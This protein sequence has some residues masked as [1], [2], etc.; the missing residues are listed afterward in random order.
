MT[1]CK[2]EINKDKNTEFSDWYVQ[3][4]IQTKL[5]DYYPI[6]G[7][8]IMLPFSYKMYLVLYI[9]LYKNI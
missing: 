2:I 3:I 5:L 1:D 6:S 7:C 8:Y 4:I 9:K